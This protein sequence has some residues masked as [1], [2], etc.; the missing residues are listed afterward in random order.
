[1]TFFF[2]VLITGL[3]VGI[4]YSLIALG[5]VL[6]ALVQ[7]SFTF[8]FARHQQQAFV[9]GADIMEVKARDSL[10]GRSETRRRQEVYTRIE[11]LEIPSIAAINGF[12]MG[13]GL[14]VALACDIRIAADDA[15]IGSPEAKV[16][17]S[18][19][20]GAFRL[21]Q[22]LVGPGKARE[23]LFTG[24]YIDGVEAQLRRQPR[25]R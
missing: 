15:K 6:L 23:L 8:L 17:S 2:E 4:M 7:G 25:R 19:T 16:T 13:G 1:M 10:L 11:Q 22:D 14:E 24:D 3:M 20:G 12:A 9:A 21:V 5:F 18:V